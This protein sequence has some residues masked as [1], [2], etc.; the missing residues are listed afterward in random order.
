[1]VGDLG[2]GEKREGLFDKLWVVLINW[3]KCGR[4]WGKK[5]DFFKMIIPEIKKT[6]EFINRE[7]LYPD[8]HVI[9]GA[10]TNPE[11]FIDGKKVLIFCSNNYLGLATEPRVEEAVID[12]VKKYGMGSGGSR[13]ISGNTI[14]QKL[15]EKSIANFKGAEDAITFATDYMANTGVIPALFNLPTISIKDYVSKK[16]FSS[17]K[18]YIFSDELNHASIV[19]GARLAKAE[20]LIYKHCD[21]DDLRKKLRSKKGGR[22]LVVT[23]GVFSMDGDIAPLD[24]IMAL[25][26]EFDASVMVDD[27]HATGILGLNGKGTAEHFALK[28]QPEITLGTFT[29][30]FGG[31]GGFIVGSKELVDYLRVTARTYIFSAPIPPAISLGLIKSLEVI[32][33]EKDRRIKLWENVDYLKKKLTES[34]FDT[35]KSETQII[36]VFIGDDQKAIAASR[37]MLEYGVFAPCVRWPAVAHGQ[38][39]LRITLMST[40]TK[41]QIDIFFDALTKTREDIGF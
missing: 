21:V 5:I 20:I 14:P 2:G 38:S 6:L 33:S 15:L 36:P 37:K 16:L 9:E 17:N 31:V 26:K 1:M 24:K 12:G 34:K 23:D 8:M 28:E 29:K 19:D 13:L 3:G 18:G 25:A 35:L 39:R 40:H 30:V 41:E 10:S 7:A 27:A 32:S 4:I 11:I 22:K